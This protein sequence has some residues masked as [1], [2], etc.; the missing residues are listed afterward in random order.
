MICLQAEL[1]TR[2][3]E[4]RCPKLLLGDLTPELT[5]RYLYSILL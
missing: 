3:Y 5:D 1:C 4:Q 2:E